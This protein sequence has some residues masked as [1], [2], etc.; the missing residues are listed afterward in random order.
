MTR[1]QVGRNYKSHHRERK[2]EGRRTPRRLQTIYIALM[3]QHRRDK[4][5]YQ[6]EFG[7]IGRRM[8]VVRW[9]LTSLDAQGIKPIV[10][11]W[12]LIGMQVEELKGMG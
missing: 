2:Q 6:A 10:H 3:N 1:S 4:C 11:L 8:P 9:S 12:P 7:R 5:N